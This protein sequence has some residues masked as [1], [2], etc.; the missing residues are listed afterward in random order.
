M[1]SE[2]FSDHL[3]GKVPYSLLHVPI[4]DMREGLRVSQ[5]FLVK[6]KT[7]RATRAGDM[8]L[9]ITLADRTGT[10]PA[11]AWAEA[12]GRYASEFSEGEFVFVQGRT[13]TYRG[14][15]QLILESIRRLSDQECD[16]GQ[17]PGFDPALL[18]QTTEHDIEAM[19]KELIVYV[20]SIEPEPLKRLTRSLCD[21]T[22]ADF[23]E[24]PAAVSIHHAYVGGLLE[25]TLEVVRGIAAF[26]DLHPYLKLHP[27]LAVSGAVLHDIGK[28]HELENPIAPRYSFHGQLIGHLLIGRDMV[29]DAAREIEWADSRIP[30]LLEH[31]LI[32]HHGE[33]EYGSAV[34]PK[35][36]EAMAIYYFDNLSAKL[37]MIRTHIASDTEDGDFT[38]KHNLLQCYLFKGTLAEG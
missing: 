10:V 11:R 27:G 36:P 32:A 29:R 13:E 37:N 4:A 15:L 5:C 17:I 35:M 38:A 7:Q 34:V 18:V 1:A 30:T 22:E 28:L 19:W 16:S 21:E 33:L 23:R 6:Q 20:D 12:A 25:H 3:Q 2:R 26:V 9:D 24:A 31:I 8:Y 14:N